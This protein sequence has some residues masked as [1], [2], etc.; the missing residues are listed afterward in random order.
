M[1]L[2]RTFACKIRECGSFK[3]GHGTAAYLVRNGGNWLR[4]KGLW[5]VW[6]GML[7]GK[8]VFGD[9]WNMV[10]VSKYILHV[11]LKKLFLYLVCMQRNMKNRH[12]I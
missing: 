1:W 2:V 4:N 8:G 7:D 9:G 6:E 3:N 12:K 11:R 10:W 5:G